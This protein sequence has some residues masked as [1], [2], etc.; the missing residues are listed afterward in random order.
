MYMRKA[1]NIWVDNQSILEKY[2]GLVP[3]LGKTT[4][5]Y[6]ELEPNT[7]LIIKGTKNGCAKAVYASKKRNVFIADDLGLKDYP[8]LLLSYLAEHNNKLFATKP[9]IKELGSKLNKAGD[10]VDTIDHYGRVRYTIDSLRDKMGFK[11]HKNDDPFV[12]TKGFGLMCTTV[13]KQI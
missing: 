8:Y 5:P 9:E 1:G 11:N 3:D 10:H 12:S 4:H 6:S 7:L 13:I 2:D